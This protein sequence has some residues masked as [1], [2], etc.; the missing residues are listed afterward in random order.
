MAREVMP[1]TKTIITWARDRAGFSLADAAAKFKNIAAWEDPN[2]EDAPTYPQ[3]EA[4]AE[5]FKVPVAVFFFPTPPK[6]PKVEETFRSVSEAAIV[7]VEPRI[8][9]LLR[10][11]KVL[12]INLA[13]LNGGRNP[14]RR[15]I[16]R[17]LRFPATI[18]AQE[19]AER[20]RDY[21]GVTLEQ[22]AAWPNPDVALEQWRARFIDAGVFAFKDQ[23][24]SDKFAGFCL[25]D[26]EFPIIYVNNTTPKTRQIFTLFHELAH[27][28]FRTSGVDF[29]HA[30]DEPRVVGR[31]AQIEVLCN[32]F[33]GKLLVPDDAFRALMHGR[34]ADLDTARDL[35]RHLNVSTLVIFRKMLDQR[36]IQSVEYEA[37]HAKAEAV[38]RE[39]KKSSGGDPH[40]SR[41]A[42]LGRAYV[43][44]ALQAFHQHRIDESQ[45][46]DYLLV[47]PRH[48]APLEERY[49]RG[50]AT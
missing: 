43:G 40:N 26:D 16:T 44:M 42:Y 9:L 12:Q 18:D 5:A 48:I 14:A 29:R 41:M 35:A 30:A 2:S 24:R 20:V 45:L 38:E 4:M 36:L 10:K 39:K 11:A 3:L 8:K 22:Q 1:V 34:A 27:L 37:A 19:M 23:F 7:A 47:K 28:L 6:V 49:I 17:D 50:S 15:L 33:A 31:A 13:E 25:S 32:R 46:A 21:L